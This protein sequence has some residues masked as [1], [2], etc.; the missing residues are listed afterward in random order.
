MRRGI[1]LSTWGGEA[2]EEYRGDQ[3]KLRTHQE[4]LRSLVMGHITHNTIQ[5]Q[6]IWAEVEPGGGKSLL[7]V[8]AYVPLRT[9]G[10][11]DKVLWVVPRRPLARQAVESFLESQHALKHD[12]AIRQ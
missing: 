11:V 5:G 1:H 10:I 12:Y 9:A 8:L 3:V 7:P 4:A 6:Q 2:G